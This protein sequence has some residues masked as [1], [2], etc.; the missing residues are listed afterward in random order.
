MHSLRG[1]LE[2]P[3]VGIVIGSP[4]SR[5]FGLRRLSACASDTYAQR[6]DGEWKMTVSDTS[7]RPLPGP[8]GLRGNL[9]VLNRLLKDPTTSLDECAALY[10]PTFAV[11][12]GP[13]RFVAVGDPAHL[14][15]V[16]SQPNASYRWG[17]ALN[18]LGFIVGPTSM[19]VSDGEDHHRRRAAVQPAF[20]RRRL[21]GWIPMI[22]SEADRMID[23]RLQPALADHGSTD[24]YPLGKDLVL[25]ITV[26]AFFGNGLEHRTAEIGTIFDELQAYLELPGPK[27]IPHRIPFTQRARAR[28]ARHRFDRIV[29]E[30]VARRRGER[31][32]NPSAETAETGDL[33]DVFVDEATST[34]TTEEI[35]DQVN[36]LIGAGYNTTAATLAWTVWRA[37]TTPDVWQ[38]LRT[39]AEEAFGDGEVPG[40][41]TLRQL[42]YAAAVVHEALRLHPAG[43]F[44]P[45]QAITD[46]PIGDHVIGKNAMVIWSPYLAGRNPD[47]WPDPLEFRPDRHLNPT[48]DAAAAQMESAWV[49]FGKGPRRCIGFAL[50]QMELTLILARLA[51]RLDLQAVNR[52]TPKPHGMV[53][54]RPTGGVIVQLASPAKIGGANE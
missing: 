7:I 22:L 19:I 8:T 54:N 29:D 30:E 42:P 50:A 16:F 36:T 45:R 17:F 4:S 35:H 48:P 13:L 5:Q 41:E 28:A 37:L 34:M 40:P 27:Q 53:V 3:I 49:P 46:V 2:R 33:L 20:A 47:A 39:E 15:D 18:V 12:V 1:A 25:A 6:S 51:Q 9:R 43:S 23:E 52:T 26:K 44:A 31:A 24:L 32:V 14:S 11:R 10:G 21:D 38:Q